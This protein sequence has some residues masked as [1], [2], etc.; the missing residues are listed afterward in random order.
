MSGRA[1]TRITGGRVFAIMSAFFGVIIAVNAT[2]AVFATR[3]WTGLVVENG[4]VASQAFNENLAEAR[5]Q[6]QLGW[7]ESFG[8]SGGKLTLILKD[9]DSGPIAGAM[10]T[11]KLQR[12]STDRQDRQIILIELAPGRYESPV[13]LSPGQWD[14]E[15]VARTVM[16]G[17]LRRLY[18]LQVRTEDAK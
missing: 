2:L 7:Q 12:P 14:A 17:S 4:Y 11:I 10:V 1:T 18:R 3:S 6:A 16:G 8:Y 13:I 15:V 9:R 5:R